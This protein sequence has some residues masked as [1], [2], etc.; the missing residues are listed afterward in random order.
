MIADTVVLIALVYVDRG[1]KAEKQFREMEAEH[2]VRRAHESGKANTRAEKS[3]V[4]EQQ[5]Q[6]QRVQKQTIPLR[7]STISVI[8]PLLMSRYKE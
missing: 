6:A 1:M 4:R 8:F 5:K 2:E 3:A 7:N